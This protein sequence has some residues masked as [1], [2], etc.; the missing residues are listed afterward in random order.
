[1]LRRLTV[2]TLAVCL[3]YCLLWTNKRVHKDSRKI[4]ICTFCSS[5]AE[6]SLA[7]C[8]CYERSID[9]AIIITRTAVRV[10]CV[11]LSRFTSGVKSAV[12]RSRDS[13]CFRLRSDVIVR[14]RSA[15][16]R[17]NE[18]QTPLPSARSAGTGKESTQPEAKIASR[19]RRS[20]P[21]E[22]EVCG[23]EEI[24]VRCQTAVPLKNSGRA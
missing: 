8:D 13:M 14:C 9:S 15:A 18:H 16:K 7:N 11:V 19:R 20:A 3:S 6:R 1:M 12:D 5:N 2:Y 4:I 23:F 17:R 22:A 21:F 10:V 24:S